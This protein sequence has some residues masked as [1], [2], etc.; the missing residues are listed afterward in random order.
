[1]ACSLGS[2]CSTVRCDS[3]LLPAYQMQALGE[4][5]TSLRNRSRLSKAWFSNDGTLRHKDVF[6]KKSLEALIEEQSGGAVILSLDCMDFM[7]R[8]LTIEPNE[9]SSIEELLSH[10]WLN[11]N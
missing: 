5:P 10:W 3:L 7:R 6:P 2:L 9:R 1:M 11:S 4:F 8:T